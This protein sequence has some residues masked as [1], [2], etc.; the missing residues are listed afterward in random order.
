MDKD[1]TDKLIAAIF[2]AAWCAQHES[3]E[4]EYVASMAASL[5]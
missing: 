2:T 3:K 5:N 4:T 1:T